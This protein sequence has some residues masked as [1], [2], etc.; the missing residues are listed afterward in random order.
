METQKTNKQIQAEKNL[1]I[2]SRSD[3]PLGRSRILVHEVLIIIPVVSIYQ[4]RQEE[5]LKAVF[6]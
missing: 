3:N 6:G 5:I 2:I 4:L 1:S